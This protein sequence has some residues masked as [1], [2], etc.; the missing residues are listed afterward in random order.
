M[1]EEREEIRVLIKE[2]QDAGARQSEAC[3]IVG[4]SAKTLQRWSQVDN[5]QDGR[6]EA[7]HEP[8]NKL[9]EQE[10]ERM[11]VLANSSEYADL[12]SNKIYA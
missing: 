8:A 4:I 11:I 12:P 9:T 6:L 7:K 1:K 3:K 10:R 2:A 5:E